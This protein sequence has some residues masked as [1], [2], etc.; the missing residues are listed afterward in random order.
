MGI[1]KAN[2]VGLVTTT[3][4]ATGNLLHTL[5]TASPTTVIIR[6][7]MWYNNTG[8]QQTIQLGTW[9]N[10]LP[11]SLFVALFPPFNCV[12]GMDG[13]LM[14]DELPEVEF[15]VDGRAAALGRTGDIYVLGSVANILVRLEVE[16]FREGR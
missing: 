2:N 13:E 11:A 10:T 9:D 8:V 6:K 1:R 15:G 4:V 3:L 16:E 5:P 7:V 12:N 14:E